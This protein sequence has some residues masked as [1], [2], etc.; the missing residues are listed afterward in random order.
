MS[1]TLFVSDL[2]LSAAHAAGIAAFKAFC[3][4]EARKAAAVYILGDLFDAW[5]GDD[6]LRERDAMEVTDALLG[7]AGAGVPVAVIGGNRDFLLGERFARAAAV[8]LLPEQVVID[9]DGEPTLLLHGDELC[10]AD[11]SYQRLR[12]YTHDARW[13]RR[14][15]ALPYGMRRIIARAMRGQSRRAV[16]TKP[17]PWTDVTDDAVAAAFRR[18]AVR[19]MIHGH[20]HRPATHRTIVDGVARERWVLAEW[21]DEGSYLEASGGELV[22][23]RVVP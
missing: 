16:A 11:S 15:L 6:Q 7:L 17:A 22:A 4:G 21:R 19:R 14:V 12:R 2:H 1:P 10:T 8:T 3:S 20:T 18:H 13:Q 23:R 5:I 9:L